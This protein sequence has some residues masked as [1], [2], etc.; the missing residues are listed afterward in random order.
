MNKNTNMRKQGF[1]IH[2]IAR[3]T[4][5]NFDSYLSLNYMFHIPNT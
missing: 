4:V 5:T 1:K 3:L 2:L